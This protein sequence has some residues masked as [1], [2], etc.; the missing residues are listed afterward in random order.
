MAIT[1]NLGRPYPIR[2]CEHSFES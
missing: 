1:Y 2:A